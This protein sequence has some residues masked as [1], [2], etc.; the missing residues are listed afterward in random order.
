[1]S[2]TPLASSIKRKLQSPDDPSD[3][4][5]NRFVTASVNSSQSDF[6]T[7]MDEQS[8]L[9][10]CSDEHDF[11]TTN[12]DSASHENQNIT[13]GNSNMEAIAA[14][15][16]ELFKFDLKESIKEQLPIMVNDI[17]SSGVTGLNVKISMLEHE[18]KKLVAENTDLKVRMNKLELAMENAEQYSRHNSLRT[19]TA[20][21]NF[22]KYT[23]LNMLLAHYARIGNFSAQL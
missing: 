23:Y 17:I 3:L 22:K 7:T 1:M 8:V 12:M 15:L 16:K 11:N 14:V 18:N 13:I 5:K 20:K 4:K 6:E 9:P 10:H 19:V 21:K 2:S